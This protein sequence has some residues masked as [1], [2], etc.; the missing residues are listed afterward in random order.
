MPPIPL[1]AFRLCV[2]ARHRPIEIGYTSISLFFDLA[3]FSVIIG[4]GLRT[5]LTAGSVA[6]S[7]PSLVHTIVH[8]ASIYFLVIFT[9]HLIFLSTL[10]FA[11]PT[12]QLLPA[13]GNDVFLPVMIARLMLSL[14][15]AATVEDG[16]SFAEMT[17]AR[18]PNEMRFA[19]DESGDYT[20][21][22]VDESWGQNRFRMLRTEGSHQ[23]T[24]DSFEEIGME[25]T[26]SW[27]EPTVSGSV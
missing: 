25:A 2:F 23:V 22:S 13:V 24:T 9:S 8:D 19:K 15:K 17:T 20:R 4:F 5:G 12:L 10:I 21:H 16:W 6:T 3:A 26:K 1:D 14:K 11:R 7:R 18:R 27:D